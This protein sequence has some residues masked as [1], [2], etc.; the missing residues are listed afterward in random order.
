MS[1]FRA[2]ALL[3]VLGFASMSLTACNTMSGA[4]EDI[5]AGGDAIHD[6]AEDAKDSM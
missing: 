5:K 2:L 1:F 4:G 3:A 6:T